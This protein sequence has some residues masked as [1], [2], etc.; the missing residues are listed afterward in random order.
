MKVLNF[1]AYIAQIDNKSPSL[2]KMTRTIQQTSMS[3]PSIQHR[4]LQYERQ[5]GGG[6]QRKRIKGD[7]I[8]VPI[9]TPH[10]W[11]WRTSVLVLRKKSYTCLATCKHYST[12]SVVLGEYLR[13]QNS[14]SPGK[15]PPVVPTTRTSHPGQQGRVTR[16]N[17][18]ESSGRTNMA[19]PG[20]HTTTRRRAQVANTQYLTYTPKKSPTIICPYR[21]IFQE[22]VPGDMRSCKNFL[23]P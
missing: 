17:K 13:E 3:N 11:Y 15:Q 9:L 6:R 16:D 7:I 1:S 18:D 12:D 4:L 22:T 21:H 10:Y 23:T 5:T 8:S 14:I 19:C 2:D 20:S